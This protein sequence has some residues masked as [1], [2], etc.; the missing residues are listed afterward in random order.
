MLGRG[1]PRMPSRRS[2]GL[3]SGST[4]PADQDARPCC[5]CRASRGPCSAPRP[6]GCARRRDRR[7]APVRGTADRL[8][9]RARTRLR[10]LSRLVAGLVRRDDRV[11]VGEAVVG[12][13]RRGC[14]SATPAAGS[15]APSRGHAVGVADGVDRRA[16]ALGQHRLPGD[17]DAGL[18][19]RRTRG[20]SPPGPPAP[21]A[22]R[23]AASAR[24]SGEASSRPA[25][26]ALIVKSYCWLLSRPGDGEGRGAAGNDDG[27]SPAPGDRVVEDPRG[28]GGR[29]VPGDGDLPVVATGHPDVLHPARLR[30]G[31]RRT[32][33][34]APVAGADAVERPARGS[35]S[36][37]RSSACG[38]RTR[39]CRTAAWRRSSPRAPC[40]GGPVLRRRRRA[41]PTPS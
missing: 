14:R 7:S 36:C 29:L 20:R 6:P 37:R 18:A 22:C 8:D 9:G 24:R 35:C 21:A 30:V 5:R 34:V 13:A 17:P 27:A 4:G 25:F 19:A 3:S 28:V 11:G 12:H 10:A 23:A 1:D 32:R 26:C 40:S 2:A 41:A 39:W 38:R 15:R 31:A 33:H 16:R